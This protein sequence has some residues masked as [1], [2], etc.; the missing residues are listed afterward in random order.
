LCSAAVAIQLSN[1]AMKYQAR[2]KKIRYKEGWNFER[3]DRMGRNML[4]FWLRSFRRNCGAIK[5]MEVEKTFIVPLPDVETGEPT[6]YAVKGVIDAIFKMKIIPLY[7]YEPDELT[8]R[9]FGKHQFCIIDWKTFLN[10]PNAVTLERSIQNA[11]Y[12]WG[13]LQMGLIP[14]IKRTASFLGVL[15]KKKTPL[16]QA[17][18]T[19]ITENLIR[20]ALKIFNDTILAIE[21]GFAMPN[22]NP[23][24]CSYCEYYDNLCQTVY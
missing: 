3:L 11:I 1:D 10:Q 24:H 17:Y 15:S 9:F 2:E 14:D 13:A 7:K 12:T 23:I 5:S 22:F 20:Q 18:Q 16:F 21:L 6:N 19:P 8:D 4:N